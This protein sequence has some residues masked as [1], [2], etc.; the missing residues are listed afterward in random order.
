MKLSLVIPAYNEAHTICDVVRAL[1]SKICDVEDSFEI[2]LVDNGSTDE[3]PKIL[4]ALRKEVPR[5]VTVRIPVNR[6]YGNGILAGLAVAKGEVLG[7]MHADNQTGAE[8]LVK[9]YQKLRIENF[10]LCK[11]SRVIRNDSTLQIVRSRLYNGLFRMMFHSPFH[12]V[13]GSPKLF[14]R[15]LYEKADLCSGGWFI[16]PEIVIKAMQLGCAVG[17]VSVSWSPRTHGSSNVKIGA[18]LEFLKNMFMY[19]F[20]K[21]E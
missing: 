15:S 4:D 11:E 2:I 17:E 5:L 3:S 7:W 13:N 20:F 19:R 6:G 9:I 12:D 16:D 1:D 21:N 10:D 18:S 14:K 8:N